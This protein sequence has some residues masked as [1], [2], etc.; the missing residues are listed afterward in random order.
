MQTL[1]YAPVR[2]NYFINITNAINLLYRENNSNFIY[3]TSEHLYP[4][5]NIIASQI[6]GLDFETNKILLYFTY[7]DTPKALIKLNIELSFILRI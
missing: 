4:K 5:S 1:S 3:L 6:S 7:F 2:K